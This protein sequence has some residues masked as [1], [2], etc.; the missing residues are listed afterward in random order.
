MIMRLKSVRSL[1]RQESGVAMVEFAYSLPLLMALG[2]GGLEIANLAVAHMRVSQIAMFVADNASR[3]RQTL[4]QAK[5]QEIFTGA[6]MTAGN[7]KNFQANAKIFLSDLE[8][9]GFTSPSPKAGQYI[10]WQCSWG[11]GSFTTSY[12]QKGDGQNDATMATGMGPTGNKITSASGTGVMFVEVA[13]TYQPLI[14]DALFGSRVI[15]Y[16]SAFN[17]RERT[18]LSLKNASGLSLCTTT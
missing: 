14:S 9:N 4:D 7:L 3:E 8:P 12:G 6:Q 16:T 5:V 15:R 13:Y 2:L 10:R 1:F 18:D 17:V 11:N